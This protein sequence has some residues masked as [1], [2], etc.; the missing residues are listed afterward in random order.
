MKILRVSLPFISLMSLLAI[1]AF[2]A[3][4][5]SGT[6][7]FRS[8]LAATNLLSLVWFLTAPLWLMPKK[9]TGELP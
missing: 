9:E 3:M 1:L 2:A 6:V 4:H 5:L 8:Y 7:S